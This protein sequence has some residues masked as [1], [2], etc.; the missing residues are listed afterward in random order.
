[1]QTNSI[2][3][4]KNILLYFLFLLPFMGQA[5]DENLKNYDHIYKE[6]I[7]SVKFTLGSLQ[8][9]Y[10]IIDMETSATLV[11][12]FDDLDGDIK[13]YTYTFTHYNADWTPSNLSD[14]EYIDGYTDETIDEYNYSFNTTTL[15]THYDLVIPN[16]DMVWT[17]SGN[18]LLKVYVEDDE[19][20]LAITRRF[21]VVDNRVQVIPKPVGAAFVNKIKTHHEMDFKVI[22]RDE[23]IRSPRTEVRAT[24]LQNGRWDNAI[25]DIKPFIIKGK[26][27]V[28]DYQDKIVFPAGREFRYVDLRS[29]KYE[30]HG[31]DVIEAYDD[32]Y[33]IH[34]LSE[35]KRRN[36]VYLRHLDA[37]GQFV[38]ENIDFQ[39]D[40]DFRSDYADVYFK[41]Y[42]PQPIH[43]SE[44]YLFGALTDWQIKPYYKM[45]YNDE[46]TSYIGEFE[47]KQGRYDYL[48]A[49]VPNG[50]T[51]PEFDETEGSWY[52][53]S[54][55]YSI[56]IYYRPFGTRYDQL[57]SA[58]TI[59]IPTR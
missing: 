10:P 37:N 3:N 54:N 36:Q 23:I 1:M 12:S 42:S 9:S 25:T 57:I 40:H 46:I 28:F 15:F 51:K 18:Y 17:K 34:L 58:Y 35:K 55:D 29:F 31:I 52:E 8:L 39:R 44:V 59:D 26:E 27:I 22:D 53:A 6:N 5:Q 14:S 20:T 2:L 30:N 11:L 56:L 49:V 24:I 19:K 41:L 38:I 4:M 50:K 47:L 45:V 43:D 7:K 13:D 33:I 32:G 48:Y 21:M 16:E